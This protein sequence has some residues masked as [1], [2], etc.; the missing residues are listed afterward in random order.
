MG[1]WKRA[2]FDS[3]AFIKQ[4]YI[5]SLV[6]TVAAAVV[7]T[8]IDWKLPGDEVAISQATTLIIYGIVAPT[9]FCVFLFTW[10]LVAA[11]HRIL[12]DRVKRVE[13]KLKEAE[14][15][16]TS[17]PRVQPVPPE[18]P[19]VQF[20]H[21]LRRISDHLKGCREDWEL[22]ERQR[23]PLGNLPPRSRDSFQE[24]LGGLRGDLADLGLDVPTLPVLDSDLS[25][26][27][28]YL[29]ELREF[30]THGDLEGAIEWTRA[31]SLDRSIEQLKK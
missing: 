29:T 12:K 1:I 28:Q 7:G 17:A 19:D 5:V 10:N 13:E 11:P 26:W 4:Y 9:I 27:T 23:R 31:W 21:L 20:R 2:W 24:V 14:T 15:R 30:A 25:M 16:E 6:L 18:A 3:W 22:V 8:S